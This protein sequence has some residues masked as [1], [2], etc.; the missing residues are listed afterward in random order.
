MRILLFFLLTLGCASQPTYKIGKVLREETV[1]MLT[2][3]YDAIPTREPD[4]KSQPALLS[5]YL[6][7]TEPTWYRVSVKTDIR[8]FPSFRESKIVGSLNPGDLIVGYEI[9]GKWM[10]IY[11]NSYAY[12]PHTEKVQRAK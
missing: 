10:R 3:N 12:I 5:D 2:D 9:E 6:E 4:V 1:V 7:D 8:D 11:E